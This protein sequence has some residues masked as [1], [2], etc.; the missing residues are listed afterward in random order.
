MSCQQTKKRYVGLDIF[1]V[2]SVLVICAFHTTIHLGGQL[3]HSSIG[4]V[5]GRYFYDSIFYAVRVF[6]VC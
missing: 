2:V 3:R 5:H 1:R 4:I 6:V